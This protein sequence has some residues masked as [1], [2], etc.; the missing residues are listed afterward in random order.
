MKRRARFWWLVSIVVTIAVAGAVGFLML[1]CRPKQVVR[2]WLVVSNPVFTTRANTQG[3]HQWVSLSLSNAGPYALVWDLC[4]LE[5][6]TQPQL[7][8]LT[9]RPVTPTNTPKSS[10][11]RPGERTEIFLE[12]LNKDSPDESCLFCCQVK[13]FEYK[14]RWY[15]LARRIEAPVYWAAALLGTQWNPS[16]RN[17]R[18]ADG[19]LFASNVDVAEYFRVTHGFICSQWLQEQQFERQKLAQAQLTLTPGTVV[20]NGR[21]EDGATGKQ[22][23]AHTKV[24]L[25]D[26]QAA[27]NASI[28]FADFCLSCTNRPVSSAP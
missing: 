26:L 8:F 19:Q 5:C 24:T 12:I 17:I 6:R 11:L 16:W 1:R 15:R 13:W 28:A 25:A 27:R 21:L 4:W 20:A 10:R 18:F 22:A 23:I 9:V 14:T 2:D 3:V 7:K